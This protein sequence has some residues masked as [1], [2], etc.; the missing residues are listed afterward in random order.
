MPDTSRL[1]H[2]SFVPEEEVSVSR[3]CAAL[4]AAVMEYERQHEE[5]DDKLYIRRGLD[6][7]LWVG[8]DAEFR[9]IEIHSYVIIDERITGQF[10]A[11]NALNEELP[12]LQ[13]HIDGARLYGFFWMTFAY[14]IDTRQFIF[15]L[16]EFSAALRRGADYLVSRVESK[17]QYRN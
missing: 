10:E 14:G 5:D 9:F 12:L 4:D 13:F 2:L 17:V 15:M 6:F 3:L 11:A 7:P 16:R 1:P 8:I